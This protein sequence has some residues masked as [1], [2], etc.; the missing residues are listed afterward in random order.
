MDEEE[1]E[2]LGDFFDK[3]DAMPESQRLSEFNRFNHTRELFARTTRP[4]V[5]N[6]NA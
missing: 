1:Q 3:L 5:G 6:S 2:K 4:F